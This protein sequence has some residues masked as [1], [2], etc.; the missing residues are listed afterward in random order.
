[1]GFVSEWASANR[2][3]IAKLDR[4]HVRSH[5]NTRSGKA[6]AHSHGNSNSNYG[7]QVEGQQGLAMGT[8]M[9]HNVQSYVGGKIQGARGGHQLGQGMFREAPQDNGRGTSGGYQGSEQQDEGQHQY[10]HQ[11]YPSAGHS[12]GRMGMPDEQSYVGEGGGYQ[13]NQYGAPSSFNQGQHGYP[14]REQDEY[15]RQQ[16]DQYGSAHGGPPPGMPMANPDFARYQQ[17]PPGPS[18]Y[19][20]PPGNYGNY[21]QGGGYQGQQGGQGG[22]QSQQGGQGGYQG[23][24]GGGYGGGY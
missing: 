8:S 19:G 2:S 5:R 6:E 1:M 20:P 23:Q 10:G 15:G 17:P 21:G 9:A 18:G 7:V 22:Y 16:E 13:Q 24:Q 14:Q 11:G 4:E 12:Q 3:G